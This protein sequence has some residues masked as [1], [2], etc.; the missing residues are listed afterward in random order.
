MTAV[1]IIRSWAAPD[2]LK[3]SRGRTGQWGTVRFTERS[4]EP[5]DF[6][7]VLNS[8]KY[9]TT[10]DVPRGRVWLVIQEPVSKAKV[11][12]FIE[13]GHEQY[14]RVFTD[15]PKCFGP[16][17]RV[18]Q[19]FLPWHVERSYDELCAASIPQ[20]TR[21]LSWIT[22]DLSR[23]DGHRRRMDF[24]KLL[25]EHQEFDLL[26][27]GFEPIKD[28]WDGLAP[29]RYTV[30]FENQYG[31]NYWTEKL[32]DAFLSWTLPF[33]YGCTTI[34]DYFP[35]NA[36]IQLG[37]DLRDA[38]QQIAQAIA[39]QQW[40]K[41]LDA[42]SEARDRVLNQHQFFPAMAKYVREAEH[43][44]RS[45]SCTLC[46]F[47]PER[48]VQMV[49]QTLPVRLLGARSMARVVKTK[50]KKLLGPRAS[51]SLSRVLHLLTR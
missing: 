38:P 23:L 45:G 12:P 50:L 8:V 10:V 14:G 41:R 16:R 18:G 47:L 24:L 43:L 22:S 33:Y 28:K 44:A 7:V 46:P 39:S 32:A 3:Q 30:A 5:Y 31:P 34:L 40:E 13:N 4:D 48:A 6:V 26:G 11:F 36:L 20:K 21:D 9:E 51:R 2:L 42:I 17:Y 49:G 25:R 15:N 1:R 35:E 27:R 19:T 37:P 29:Y